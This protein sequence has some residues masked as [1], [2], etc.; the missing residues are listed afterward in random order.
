MAINRKTNSL[1]ALPHGSNEDAQEKSEK[2]LH[3]QY[4]Q[5]HTDIYRHTHINTHTNAHIYTHKHLCL[6]TSWNKPNLNNEKWWQWKFKTLKRQ[7]EEDMK[8]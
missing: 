5:T 6:Q 3:I 1:S 2:A 4:T 7:T 8:K